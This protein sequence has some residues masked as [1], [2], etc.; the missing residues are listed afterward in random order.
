MNIKTYVFIFLISTVLFSGC[1]PVRTVKQMIGTSVYPLEIQKESASAVIDKDYALC[2]ERTLEILQEIGANAYLK[3]QRRQYIV[4]IRFSDIFPRC[5]DSSKVGFFFEKIDPKKTKI[6]IKS[7]N[8]HL[9]EF[10]AQMLFE[11][12][13]T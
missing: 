6:I 5:G 8:T 2:Y 12:L 11:H 13:K 1:S 9:A 10:V 7:Q 3:N 4:A